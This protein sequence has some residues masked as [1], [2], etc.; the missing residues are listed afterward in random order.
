MYFHIVIGFIILLFNFNNIKQVIIDNYKYLCYR[1]VNLYLENKIY[2][3][4]E[5]TEK[6]I[7]KIIDEMDKQENDIN[8]I[9][10]SNGGELLSGYNLIHEFDRIRDFKKI[11]CYAINAYSTAFTIF[12]YCSNR[13]V[14]PDSK[15][16]QHNISINFKG[17]FEE[18]EDF[19]QNK[20]HL[21]RFITFIMTREV[22]ERIKMNYD[23]F[24]QKIWND[25]NIEGGENIVKNNLADEVVI[26]KMDF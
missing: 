9:I 26:L 19:Y 21:Y 23:D 8:L 11:N 1:R 16:F 5:I 3:E 20:Y 25:W 15:L 18:F 2:I 14:M 4:N 13:Y 17:S 7:Q 6:S 10:D 24:I 22:S 12:Q